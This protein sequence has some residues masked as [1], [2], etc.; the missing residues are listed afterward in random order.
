MIQSA[1]CIK[2]RDE[3]EEDTEAAAPVADISF[4]QQG[5]GKICKTGQTAA[6][7]YTGSLATDGSVFDSSIPRGSPI[8]FEI[9]SHRV[10]KCWEQAIIQLHVG[11][12]A[13]LDCP[14][15]LA[16]GQRTKPGI[17]AGSELKFAVEVV[18]C[19]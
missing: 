15:E 19:D 7:H 10:I 8:K 1:E 17:P 18:S 13:D 12:K 6:V 14:P 3:D 5:D 16:Y 2:V 4:S 9:G 11:D